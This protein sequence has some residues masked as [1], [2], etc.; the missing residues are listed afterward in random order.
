MRAYTKKRLGNYNDNHEGQQKLDF[1]FNVFQKALTD[2]RNWD[3]D[4]CDFENF[5][6]GVLKSEISSYHEKAKRR[7]PPEEENEN[8]E[9]YIL[10]IPV[11]LEEVG[12]N[13]QSF[14][15]IDNKKLKEDYV[16]LLKDSGA[17]DLEMLIFECWCEDIYK[18]S[19]ISDF[20]EIDSTEVYNA[21]KRLER[22]KKKL[23][24]QVK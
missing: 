2:I 21:V 6:F 7:K 9:S 10:D 4:K 13:D 11:F 16:T 14:K 22:R 1:V 23:N 12:Y 5:L 3:K 19:E 20:L 15:E 18:P 17:S 8:E 24:S